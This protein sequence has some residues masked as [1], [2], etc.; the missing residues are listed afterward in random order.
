MRE[1]PDNASLDHLRQQAKDLLVVLRRHDAAATLTHAQSDLALQHGFDSWAALKAEVQRKRSEPAV[2]AD[3]ALACQLAR[4]YDLGEVAGP[5]THVETQWAGAVWDLSTS[6]G[7]WVVTALKPYVMP[8]NIEIQADLV[9]RAIAAGVLAPIPVRS[10]EGPFVADVDGSSWCVHRWQRLGPTPPIPVS[11]DIAAEGGRIL[12]LIHSL[13]VPPPAPVVG[14]LTHRWGE[15]RWREMVDRARAQGKVWA[16]DLAAAIPGFLELDQ[17]CDPTDPNE[18]A[19]FTK[20]WHAP[21]GVRLAGDRLVAVAWEH[22]GAVPKDWDLGS[23]L[24]AWS[25][26]AGGDYEV[27]PAQA[28][29]SGYRETGAD[30]PIALP[31]FT[32]SVSAA[33]NWTISRANIATCADSTD[34]E[35]ALAERTIRVLARQPLTL[36]HV[37]RLAA[38]LS[39]T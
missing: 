9:E 29:L 1:L 32:C 3:P 4:T 37:E 25:E 38:A 11:N 34:E 19:I 17:V 36:A 20:A 8:E 30:I 31:M 13:D 33:L 27:A 2:I 22:A 23:C 39:S 28:F 18:R 5:M 14:W 24:T 21:P 10:T 7:R 6:S 16:D 15:D 35:R 12:A 26:T